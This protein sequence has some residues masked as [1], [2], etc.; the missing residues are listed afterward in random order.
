MAIDNLYPYFGDASYDSF[1]HLAG[2]VA[3]CS[4]RKKG[5]LFIAS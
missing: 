2:V 3:R 5:G 4:W 1:S